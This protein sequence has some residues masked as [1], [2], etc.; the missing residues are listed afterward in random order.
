MKWVVL[1]FLI[2]VDNLLLVFTSLNVEDEFLLGELV[3]LV[4]WTGG[5]FLSA[6]LHLLEKESQFKEKKEFYKLVRQ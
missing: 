3:S 4:E 5:H 2:Q 1:A 6:F